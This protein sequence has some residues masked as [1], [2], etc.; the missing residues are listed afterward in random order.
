MAS[1]SPELANL[2]K[3]LDRVREIFYNNDMQ[4]MEA[5]NIVG[6]MIRSG[7]NHRQAFAILVEDINEFEFED[8]KKIQ[9]LVIELLKKQVDR[10]ELVIVLSERAPGILDK[11]LSEY[12]NHDYAPF[13]G[14]YLR[15][16]TQF[17]VL[18][19][20]WCRMARI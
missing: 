14:E 19:K 11:L 13:I 6:Q 17:P 10:N 3:Y 15:V 2:H 7:S 9:E 4:A 12:E 16:F 5:E 8:R 18:L 20:A 1:A